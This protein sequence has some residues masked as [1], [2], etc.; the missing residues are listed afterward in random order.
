[1]PRRLGGDAGLKPTDEFDARLDPDADGLTN[2]QEFAIGTMRKIADTDGDT[3]NDGR[4]VLGTKPLIRDSDGDLLD[5]GF[6][7]V[8]GF[9]ALT[10][11]ETD[12]DNDGDTPI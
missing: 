11:G 6:E 9:N 12:Q 10:V 7:V 5:D 4:E 1:M 3:L 8:N 2:R